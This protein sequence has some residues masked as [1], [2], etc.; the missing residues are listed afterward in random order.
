MV[1]GNT[2]DWQQWAEHWC[3]YC[4]RQLVRLVLSYLWR[5]QAV[6]RDEHSSGGEQGMAAASFEVSGGLIPEKDLPSSDNSFFVS[7]ILTY[8]LDFASFSR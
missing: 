3:G 5:Q 6:S 1:D 4:L 8:F 2:I 7:P